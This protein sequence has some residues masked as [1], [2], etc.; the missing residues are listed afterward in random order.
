VLLKSRVNRLETVARDDMA[1][2]TCRSLIALEEV[3]PSD[4]VRSYGA[5]IF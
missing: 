2:W 3:A 5:L 4:A 1:Y